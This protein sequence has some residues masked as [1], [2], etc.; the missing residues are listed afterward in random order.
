MPTQRSV[1]DA[2][3]SQSADPDARSRA[4]FS[5]CLREWTEADDLERAVQQIEAQVPGFK[6]GLCPY[7]WQ[8]RLLSGEDEPRI[9]LCRGL[10]DIL[11]NIRFGKK[12]TTNAHIVALA[13]SP[14]VA[15]LETLSIG[16]G[17]FGAKAAV[18][19]ASSP[20]LSRLR[21]LSFRYFKP[22][23]AGMKALGASQT[24]RALTTLN[25]FGN[26]VDDAAM[27]AFC[28][29]DGLRTLE[30]L[31][32][33]HCQVGPDGAAALA[34]AS[35]LTALHTLSMAFNPLGPAGVTA[36][37]AGPFPALRTLDLVNTRAADDDA[38]AHLAAAP[39]I[40]SLSTLS[41]SLKAIGP[42]LIA[43]VHSAT[44]LKRLSVH[45]LSAEAAETLKAEMMP[46]IALST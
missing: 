5:F 28:A 20:N 37:A 42:G 43:L 23:R 33:T 45:G 38:A 19:V 31:D 6:L 1:L 21:E 39:W 41:L 9:R 3:L 36:L 35:R 10:S 22:G 40:G 17:T 26:T 4:L 44:S 30:K 14:H 29:E 11:K 25:M 27:G 7:P 12:K 15:N 2:I 32:L 8:V 18:A 16:S 24:L 46:G 13:R 34:T